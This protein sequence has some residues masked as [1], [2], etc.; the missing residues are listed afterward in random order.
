LPDQ[1]PE[2]LEKIFSN[3]YR[4]ESAIKISSWLDGVALPD[5]TNEVAISLTAHLRMAYLDV[6]IENF[7]TV[8]VLG[9]G[10]IVSSPLG[11]TAF[12]LN[13]GGPIVSTDLDVVILTPICASRPIRPIVLPSAAKM[14]I[15]SIRQGIET[16]VTI[17]GIFVRKFP[18]HSELVVAASKNRTNLVRFTKRY[19]GQRTW[20]LAKGE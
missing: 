6:E 7:G 9:D 4:L 16:A 19:M 12:S 13:A 3:D 18:L 1:I 20:R 2:A 14:K 15:K 5:A 10:A 11:S 17:D 8:Q